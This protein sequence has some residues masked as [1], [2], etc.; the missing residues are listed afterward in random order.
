MDSLTIK[1]QNVHLKRK[2]DDDN[3]DDVPITTKYETKES[4][5]EHIK[6]KNTWSSDSVIKFLNAYDD[7]LLSSHLQKIRTQYKD[8]SYIS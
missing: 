5:I 4:I 1:M 8:C 2:R 6:T 3:S 7:I